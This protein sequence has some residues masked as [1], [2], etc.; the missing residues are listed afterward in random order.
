MLGK[1]S[2]DVEPS[3]N[4][5][6]SPGNR[7]KGSF[8]N[9]HLYIYLTHYNSS[10]VGARECGVISN[11]TSILAIAIGKC[12]KR[13]YGYTTSITGEIFM[14]DINIEA[15]KHTIAVLQLDHQ[16]DPAMEE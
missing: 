10:N 12:L 4:C 15:W 8:Y 16:N 3:R 9:H 14:F 2:D 11:F 5:L 13:G 6:S 1:C 7:L